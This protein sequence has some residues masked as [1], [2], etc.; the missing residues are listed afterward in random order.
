MRI[1]DINSRNVLLDEE[2]IWNFLIY[3]ILYKISLGSTPLRI[4]FDEFKNY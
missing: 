1:I 3:D 2:K 4:R